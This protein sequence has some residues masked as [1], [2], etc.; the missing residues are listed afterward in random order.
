MARTQNGEFLLVRQFRPALERESLELPGGILEP[1]EEPASCATREL[2]EEAGARLTQPLQFLG[3]VDPDSGR[4]ENSQWCF[5]ADAVQLVPDWT[6]ETGVQRVILTAA[7]LRD[8]IL[9]GSF[10]HALHLAALA[11]ALL[12]GLVAV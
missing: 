9:E 6:P 2:F 7:E 4:L 11:L 3:R 12:R 10:C 8:A 1:G 5:F